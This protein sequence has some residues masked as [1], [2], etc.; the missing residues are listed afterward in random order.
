VLGL[1]YA[2]REGVNAKG[3]G[4]AFAD[5]GEVKRAY[6][7]GQVSCTPRSSCA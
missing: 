5:V 7:S 4:M 1:Y 3:E 6:E 2:T